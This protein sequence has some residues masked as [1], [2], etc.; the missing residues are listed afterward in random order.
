MDFAFALFEL[1]TEFVYVAEETDVFFDEEGFAIGVTFFE[2]FDYLVAS[3]FVPVR[4]V[5]N[6]MLLGHQEVV[7]YRPII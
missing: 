2:F 5:S 1:F 3:F 6:G 7:T 4:I